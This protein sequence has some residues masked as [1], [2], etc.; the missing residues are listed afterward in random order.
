MLLPAMLLSRS[1]GRILGVCAGMLSLI[2]GAVS[3]TELA[4]SSKPLIILVHGWTCDA[5]FWADQIPALETKYRVIAPDLPGHGS[6]PL[7]PGGLQEFSFVEAVDR[8]VEK[9]TAQRA[10]LMGHSLGGAVIRQY[11]R[12]HPERVIA[13]IFVET[14]FHI[15]DSPEMRAWAEAFGG[16]EGLKTRRAFVESMFSAAATPA[17]REKILSTMLA[18][19][20]E[21]A[22]QAARWLVQPQTMRTDDRFPQPV[23]NVVEAPTRP[24][25]DWM[26]AMF[27]K[28]ERVEIEGVGH[29]LMMEK[30]EEFNRVLLAFLAKLPA[31]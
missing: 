11:A 22:V 15:P 7:P 1:A 26:S 29:F 16:P 5:T 14:P 18:T 3:A 8:A 31:G 24:L 27:P 28:F 17:L 9:A 23:L 4:D 12:L 19:P 30:P 25:R 6:S 20:E 10:I 13:L 21:V 2:S